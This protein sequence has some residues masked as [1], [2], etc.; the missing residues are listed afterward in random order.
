METGVHV[1]VHATNLE[2]KTLDTLT[3]ST[4]SHS[5]WHTLT[6]SLRET[7]KWVESL[8]HF[9]DDHR[10]L[11][12]AHTVDFFTLRH[13]EKVVP[14]GWR[15]EVEREGL[16]VEEVVNPTAGGEDGMGGGLSHV[17]ACTCTYICLNTIISVTC[18][19]LPLSLLSHTSSLPPSLPPSNSRFSE[20]IPQHSKVS[21]TASGMG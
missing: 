13:W 3:K 18:F 8:Y 20:E 21:L 17:H 7:Q 6:P 12:E 10:S 14:E 11:C 16:S 9:L 4:P 5:H 15:E 2:R 19:L 1:H